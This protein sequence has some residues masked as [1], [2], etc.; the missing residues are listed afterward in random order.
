MQRQDV[1]QVTEIDREAFP[2]M[3]P[4]VNYGRE[5]DNSLAHYIVAYEET[6]NPEPEA[7][8]NNGSG[9][10]FAAF[11]QGIF[12][13]NRDNFPKKDTPKPV[14]Q[15]ILGFAGFW[16]VAQEAHVISIAVHADYRRQGV[17]ELLFISMLELAM[18]MDA[19]TVSLEAR[20]SN[21]GAHQ[22]YYKYGLKNVGLRRKYY[23]NDKEDAVVMTADDIATPEYQERLQQLKQK[24]SGKWGIAQYNISS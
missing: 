21:T 9:S 13:R 23:I 16:F 5:L 22:L 4:P 8:G 19:H 6:V 3:W 10:G 24:H 15:H 2:G 12:R 1:P 11:M 17:G 7:A 14:S 20:V 18:G